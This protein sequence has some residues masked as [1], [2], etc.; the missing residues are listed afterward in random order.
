ML[1]L[2]FTRQFK[3]DFKKAEKRG[4]DLQQLWKIATLLIEEEELPEVNRDH[5]LLNSLNYKNT[6]ECHL[7]PDL[8][9]IYKVYEEISIIEMVRLG[10]HS[11]LFR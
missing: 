3:R 11:D 2:K 10:T 4:C 8:L 9:L 6:R 1:R 7:A 5:L